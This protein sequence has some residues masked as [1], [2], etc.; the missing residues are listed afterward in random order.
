MKISQRVVL[1]YKVRQQKKHNFLRAAFKTLKILAAIFL[2]GFVTLRVYD[3]L[4]RSDFFLVKSITF[5][6]QNDLSSRIAADLKSFMG[7]SI[8]FI[9][10][11]KAESDIRERY[12]EISTLSLRRAL[13]DGMT[14]T[15]SL[16][17]PQAFVRTSKDFKGIDLEGKVFPLS[18]NQEPLPELVLNGAS[19]PTEPPDSLKFLES[20]KKAVQKLEAP[21][22]WRLAKVTV[23]EYGELSAE[24]FE[25]APR[26]LAWGRAEPENFEEK[27]KRLMQVSRDLTERKILAKTIDL[28][29]IPGKAGT[30]DSKT[31]LGRV[32]VSKNH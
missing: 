13:P 25:G 20:W 1:R 14:V 6:E 17:S 9:S 8:F 3:F 29:E 24:L 4:F 27:F 23:D 31:I 22:S 15:L 19:S 10:P 32:L 7:K 18:R 5:N 28:S 26:I 2:M 21:Q 12:P 11:R 16:R 30:K